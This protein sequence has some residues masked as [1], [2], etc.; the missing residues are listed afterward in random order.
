MY[1]ALNLEDNPLTKGGHQAVA[2][3]HAGNSLMDDAIGRQAAG[4]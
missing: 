1:Y 4:R 3:S 2:P